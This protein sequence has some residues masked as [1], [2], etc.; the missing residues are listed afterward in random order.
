MKLLTIS[1]LIGV[2]MLYYATKTGSIDVGVYGM[3]LFV[4]SA[5]FMIVLA[6][7]KSKGEAGTTNIH[8]THHHHHKE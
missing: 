1:L 6:F 3:T 7:K 2:A 8:I 5:F 4:F